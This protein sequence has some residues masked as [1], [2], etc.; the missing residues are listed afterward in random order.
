MNDYENL[1]DKARSE[2]IDIEDM[3][4]RFEIPKVRGH[5]EGNKT[6]IS[7]YHQI[8]KKLS[9]DPKHLLK[10]L[11]KNLAT[12]GELYDKGVIFGSKISSSEINKAIAN[13][14][15]EFVICSE[16]KKPDTKI[17]KESGIHFIKCMVCGNKKPIKYNI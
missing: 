14:T 10:Y 6:I 13:Y 4:S 8:A 3:Q 2:T 9:R 5:V 7:N 12:P 17:K 11:Q 16:C 1:L 15:N